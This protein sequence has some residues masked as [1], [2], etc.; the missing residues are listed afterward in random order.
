MNDTLVKLASTHMNMGQVMLV[1]GL[2]ATVL[3]G[4]LAWHQG[5]LRSPRQ[6]L[7]PAIAVRVVGE[8]G[9]T[10]FFLVALAHLPIAN[11]SA[12]LQALPLAVTMGAALLFGERVGPRRWL[13]IAAGFTGVMIIVRPG[14]EGFNIYALMVLVSVGFCAI[15][16]L[17]T[18]RIPKTVPSLLVSVITAVVVTVFGAFLVVPLGGWTPMSVEVT[19]TLAGAA[20]LLLFGYQFIIMS[21]RVGEISFIAP[22]RYTALLWAILLGHVIFD[23]TPD[24]P[25]ILGA[26]IIVVSGLYMLYRERVVGPRLTAAESTGP[27]MAPDGI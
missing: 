1:R 11:V 26:S 21:M 19:G 25:M 16:D 14:F 15:R 3:V 2:F 6:A 24:A 8:L 4:A 22:F 5:A 17:A 18:K 20:V 23:D 10:L 27:A 9:G 12:V 13:S 7:H